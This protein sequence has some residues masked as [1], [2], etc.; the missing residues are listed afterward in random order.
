M[1]TPAVTALEHS[2]V[3]FDLAPYRHDPTT[4]AYGLE[5][6]TAL[7]VAPAR[8]FK[9]LVVTGERMYLGIV[10]VTHRLSLKQ[11]ALAVGERRLA[12]C[13]PADAERATG[14]V[15]GGISPFGTRRPVSAVI[16]VSVRDHDTV[17]V[18]GGRRGLDICI[19]VDDLIE[20]SGAVVHSIA[21]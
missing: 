8:V 14:Y 2:G 3:A 16:D 9:T 10:P 5:A 11:M 1:M 20:V 7:G 6:A 18:S 4:E 21:V 12:M 13:P 15:V 17:Y 19:G